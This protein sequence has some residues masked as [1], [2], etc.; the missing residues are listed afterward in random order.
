MSRRHRHRGRYELQAGERFLLQSAG[1]GGYGDP[2]KRE[3]AALTQD[4]TEGYVSA[5]AAARDY[6]SKG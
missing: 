1:G 4:I 6:G 2:R 5:G 3:R